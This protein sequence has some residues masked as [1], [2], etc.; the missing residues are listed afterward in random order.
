MIPGA[1]TTIL[2]H[3]VESDADGLSHM[4]R[5]LLHSDALIT[6]ASAPTGAGKSY[7]FRKALVRGERI[8]FVVPTRRLGQNQ[9]ASMRA[10]VCDP[11]IARKEGFEVWDAATA[12][13]KIQRWDS[14]Y[15][16]IIKQVRRERPSQHYSRKIGLL[17]YDEGGEIIFT[18]PELVSNL[19]L[20]I[21]KDGNRGDI[22]PDYII[23]QFDRIVFDEFHLI[24]E[25]GFGFL[26][27]L[28]AVAKHF[29]DT[30]GQEVNHA[31]IVLLSAT[32]IDI[33]PVLEKLR[34][35]LETDVRFVDEHLSQDGGRALH[36]DV[37]LEFKFAPDVCTLLS[38]MEQEN[39]ALSAISRDNKM[40]V[41]YDSLRKLK[42][43]KSSVIE[44]LEKSG[45]KRH[46]ILFDNSQD[47]QY[48]SDVTGAS[49]DLDSK[50]VIIATSSLEVGVTVRNM[51]TLV[52]NP[53]HKPLSLMQR[54]GRV[55]RGDY[56]G[57]AIVAFDAKNYDRKPW[58]RSI[59]ADIQEKDGPVSIEELTGI[60]TRAANLGELFDASSLPDISEDGEMEG[61]LV[62]HTYGRI[63]KR[64][65]FCS[66]LYW[67]SVISA[68]RGAGLHNKAQFLISVQPSQARLVWTWMERI[69][70]D[71]PHGKQWVAAFMKEGRDL[72]GFS[73]DI[74]VV[75]EAT[76]AQMRVPEEWL[77]LHTNIF[78]THPLVID[79]QGDPVIMVRDFGVIDRSIREKGKLGRYSREILLPNGTTAYLP[80]RCRSPVSW[81]VSTIEESRL[82][83]GSKGENLKKVMKGLV[84]LTGIIPYADTEQDVPDNAVSGII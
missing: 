18:T 14:D 78:E 84:A 77:A 8:L 32:P 12:E 63:G 13:A 23:S 52:C 5:E 66:G 10:D 6:I 4:Q 54:I 21:W 2:R 49:H 62:T 70:K 81:Y 28:A 41:I 71:L 37:R 55:A 50:S 22:T 42:E 64:A 69:K 3:C 60:A 51:R 58:L 61:E 83:F 38:D 45:V 73:P 46:E 31:R 43:E 33:S 24:E 75:C 35:N 30:A 29:Q 26:A 74:K 48:E 53:G 27:T 40:V 9:C 72:R 65:V 56:T 79:R 7:V 44:L 1:S 34:F 80:G 59:I 47:A 57:L 20:N 67:C 19:F 16:Q 82:A 76:N 17:S 36:G 15:S 68:L 39:G 25:R 11:D